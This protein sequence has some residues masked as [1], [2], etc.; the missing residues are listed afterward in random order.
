MRS[1]FSTLEDLEFVDD[2]ALLLNTHSQIQNKTRQLN[3]YAN[4]LDLKISL[5]KT[6]VMTL[7]ESN[8]SPIQNE[9]QNI[10]HTE[11]FTY[12][13]RVIKSDDGSNSDIKYRPNNETVTLN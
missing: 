2:V 1:L 12:V 9:D 7:N 4:Q 5:K 13:D 8:P 3:K 10:Q 11:S 6:E